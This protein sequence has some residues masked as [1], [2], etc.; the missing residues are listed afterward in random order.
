MATNG[1]R[2]TPAIRVIERI[3]IGPPPA[4]TPPPLII[5]FTQRAGAPPDADQVPSN[6]HRTPSR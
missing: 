3:V 2:E 4:R 1:Q 6:G 5:T